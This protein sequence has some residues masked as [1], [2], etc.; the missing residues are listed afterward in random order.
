VLGILGS[1]VFGVP[2]WHVTQLVPVFTLSTPIAPASPCIN[3]SSLRLYGGYY[4]V[5]NSVA[6]RV[7]CFILPS[8]CHFHLHLPP[9]PSPL[10]QSY[11]WS[12]SVSSSHTHAL[13]VTCLRR[14]LVHNPLCASSSMQCDNTSCCVTFPQK[15][16][17]ILRT[18]FLSIPLTTLALPR[19]SFILPFKFMVTFLRRPSLSLLALRLTMCYSPCQ[20]HGS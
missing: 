13:S 12:S 8:T 16:L 6:L 10:Q 18:S 19:I 14:H 7:T 4:G 3:M 1:P 17:Y 9:S 20:V 5:S 11:I 2:Y 15:V